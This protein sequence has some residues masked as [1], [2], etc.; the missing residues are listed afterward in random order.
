[1]L[2]KTI[3]LFAFWRGVMTV[4]NGWKVGPYL[5]GT[6]ESFNDQNAW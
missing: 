1:M 4:T 5:G 3:L 6:V 2:R